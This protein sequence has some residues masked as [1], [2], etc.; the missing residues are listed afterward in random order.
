MVHEFTIQRG[1]EHER[2]ITLLK[3]NE[4]TAV[5][6]CSLM[7]HAESSINKPLS[8]LHTENSPVTSALA[9]GGSGSLG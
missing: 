6:Y 4:I 3:A 1:E 9:F 2:Y 7:V 5:L 8:P